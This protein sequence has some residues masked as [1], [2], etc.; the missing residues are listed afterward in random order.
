M[1]KVNKEKKNPS[2]VKKTENKLQKQYVHVVTTSI[3]QQTY[4]NFYEAFL[5]TMETEITVFSKKEDADA[6]LEKQLSKA[7]KKLNL[8]HSE[9]KRTS[10]CVSIEYDDEQ[11]FHGYIVKKEVK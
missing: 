5:P 1:S 7:N 6:F 8:S 2:P 9:I 11:V 4:D 3:M 10:K